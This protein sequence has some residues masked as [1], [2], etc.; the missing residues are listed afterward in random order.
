VTVEQIQ[1][2]RSVLPIAAVQ[3]RYNVVD[4][5]HDEVVDHCAAEGIAFVP[6]YPLHGDHP[7]LAEVAARHGV[8][9]DQVKLAWLMRRS[10]NVLPIPGTRSPGHLRENLAALD[11][12]L[13]GEDVDALAP[14]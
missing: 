13:A 4:R 10:P 1:R 14:E 11:V 9:P 2:G 7:A 6:F 12:E 8:T 3:N 5:K